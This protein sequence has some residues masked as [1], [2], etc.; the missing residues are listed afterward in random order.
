MFVLEKASPRNASCTYSKS[1]KICDK[2]SSVAVGFD[3]IV[4]HL[5]PAQMGFSLIV[6]GWKVPLGQK[7]GVVVRDLYYRTLGGHLGILGLKREARSELKLGVSIPAWV[8][9]FMLAIE[10]AF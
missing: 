5:S 9:R 3:S 4:L 10:L 2:W 1:D 7:N 6:E 8:N